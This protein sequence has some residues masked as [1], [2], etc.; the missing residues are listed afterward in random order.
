MI[1]GLQVYVNEERREFI[2]VGSST[3][4]VVADSFPSL[5]FVLQKGAQSEPLKQ[6]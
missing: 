3:V 1:L 4:C 6:H 2:D 5:V